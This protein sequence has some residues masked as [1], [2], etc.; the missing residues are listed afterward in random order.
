[1]SLDSVWLLYKVVV[2]EKLFSLFPRE[3]TLIIICQL[4][5]YMLPNQAVHQVRLNH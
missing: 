4:K 2:A 5:R 1:M 3:R